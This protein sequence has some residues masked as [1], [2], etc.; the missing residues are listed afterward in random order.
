MSKKT[1]TRYCQGCQSNQ[2]HDKRD[3]FDRE[4]ALGKF[5]IGVA[6]IGYIFVDTQKWWQCQKCGKKTSR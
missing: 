3:E 6:S 4:G 1:E 2:L 5:L